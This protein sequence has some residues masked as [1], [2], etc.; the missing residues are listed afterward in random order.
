[1][2]VAGRA[3]EREVEGLG[4]FDA[5]GG[6]RTEASRAAGQHARDTQSRRR[7]ADRAC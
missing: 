5:D 6:L 4:A 7:H 1:M 3:V 2:W